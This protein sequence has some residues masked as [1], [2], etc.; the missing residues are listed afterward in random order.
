[1]PFLRAAD[2]VSLVSV[3]NE[4]ETAGL[5]PGAEIAPQ[6]ARHDIEVEV[7]D[8]MH[9]GNAGDTLLQYAKKID[10]DMLVMGAFAHS[11]WRQFVLGG[12]TTTMLTKA[13][14]PVFMSH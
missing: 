4:K 12:V 1:M 14:V 8:L 10:A 9:I 11:T 13:H 3:V 6:L 5:L 2:K 7:V